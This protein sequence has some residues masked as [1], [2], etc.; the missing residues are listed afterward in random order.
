MQ[1]LLGGIIGAVI[2]TFAWLGIEHVQQ[3]NYTWLV[4]AV[5]LIT[6]LGVKMGGANKS[7]GFTRGALALILTLA[8][9]VGG[10]QAYAKYR[11]ATVLASASESVKQKA[12]TQEATPD[13]EETDSETASTASTAAR[14]EVA[15]DPV[16]FE[17]TTY[18]KTA[19]RKNLSDSDMIWMCAA[20]LVAYVTGKGGD[21][22]PIA[23]AE[24]AS[25]ES[26]QSA[27]DEGE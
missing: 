13:G 26:D 3:V 9:I 1:A 22:K 6:G 4:V 7:A 25:P 24:H 23:T 18:T 14:E 2:S 16:N 10:Q 5:G 21:P 27:A 20:A 17:Q 11:Q 19:M 15:A 12:E 8:A